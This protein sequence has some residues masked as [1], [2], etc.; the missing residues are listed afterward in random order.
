MIVCRAMLMFWNVNVIRCEVCY[1]KFT[2]QVPCLLS[3]NECQ[4]E[5][6]SGAD[7]K[8]ILRFDDKSMKH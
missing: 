1:M 7:V 8:G 4:S 5:F 3:T 2:Y 6:W